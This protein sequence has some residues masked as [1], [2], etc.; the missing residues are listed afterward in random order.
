MLYRF[1]FKILYYTSISH[2]GYIEAIEQQ[3]NLKLKFVV[4]R[5]Y[6]D[7]RNKFSHSNVHP[8]RCDAHV[9][10]VNKFFNSMENIFILGS[11]KSPLGNK[12]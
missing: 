1:L 5:Q 8:K 9:L 11:L 4:R 6:A 12:S 3:L 10:E 2:K 7:I